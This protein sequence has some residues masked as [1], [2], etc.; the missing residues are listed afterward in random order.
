MEQHLVYDIGVESLFKGL[1]ARLTPALKHAVRELGVDLDKRLL[2][3][4]PKSVWVRVVDEVARIVSPQLEVG[5]AHRQLGHAISAGFA[6]S[7]MGRLMAPGVRLMGVRRVMLRLPKNLTMS[8]NFMRVTA[9]ET[10]PRSIR[11]EMNEAIPSEAFL[12]GVIEAIGRYAGAKSCEIST[13][14]E[15]GVIAFSVTWTE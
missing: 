11:V 6:D 1:G 7:V 2:P 8:N 3:A 4:Y 10:G 12:C 14:P 15:N 13:A 5:E 9:T